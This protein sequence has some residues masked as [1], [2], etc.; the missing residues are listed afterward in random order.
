M[1]DD[2]NTRREDFDFGK[3]ATKKALQARHRARLASQAVVE[4]PREGPQRCP[5][6]DGTGIV[7][8]TLSDCGRCGGTGER[9]TGIASVEH[10]RAIRFAAENMGSHPASI[11]NELCDSHESLRSALSAAQHDGE[12]ARESYDKLRYALMRHNQSVPSPYR[13]DVPASRPP[14][15]DGPRT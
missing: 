14:S 12:A 4:P 9:T 2:M 11:I 1:S 7:P 15:T 10:V 6:C 3:P 8:G 13:F 5:D